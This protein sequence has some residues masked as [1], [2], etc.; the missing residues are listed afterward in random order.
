MAEVFRQAH[1]WE[2][3]NYLRADQSVSVVGPRRIGK[4][5]LL[6]HLRRDSTRA[7]VLMGPE[8]LLVYQDCA[9]LAGGPETE[10]HAQLCMEISTALGLWPGPE[11]A[12][13]SPDRRSRLS[14]RPYED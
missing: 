6:Q 7:A 10:V 9:V 5:S 13:Q 8:N 3:A 14:G 1:C 11:P 4:S 2:I 12:R